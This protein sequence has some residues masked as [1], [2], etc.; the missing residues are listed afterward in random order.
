MYD[1][2]M[3]QS[4]RCFMLVHVT[5]RKE[6]MK[7]LSLPLLILGSKS[8]R[9]ATCR[10]LPKPCLPGGNF[11]SSCGT[12]IHKC[13][14][15]FWY[16]FV[17][18][19]GNVTSSLMSKKDSTACPYPQN[20]SIFCWLFPTGWGHTVTTP[21]VFWWPSSICKLPRRI[22]ETPPIARDMRIS[23]TSKWEILHWLVHHPFNPIYRGMFCRRAT[24]LFTSLRAVK[25]KS[26][27]GWR[28]KQIDIANITLK[29][30]RR[31]TRGG[32][33]DVDDDVDEK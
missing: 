3:A 1:T 12:G 5:F 15:I 26:G 17:A 32:W 9:F 2:I 18:I 8:F 6:I 22:G 25:T 10:H 23:R 33:R 21:L 7:W 30:V 20:A 31:T 19:F 4:Q 11:L 29:V 28:A 16:I 14:L 27:K 24:N 13:H